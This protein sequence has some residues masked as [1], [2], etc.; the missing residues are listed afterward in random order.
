[1]VHL[2]CIL[3]FTDR[4]KTDSLPLWT[5]SSSF[6]DN[7]NLTRYRLWLE[8]QYGL[9]FEDYEALWRWST[10]QV[11]SFWKSIWDYFELSKNPWQGPVMSNDAMPDTQWF[12]GAQINYAEQIFRRYTNDHPAIL[13][14]SERHPLT[15]ISWSELRDKVGRLRSFL[16]NAGVHKGDRVAAFIPNIPEATYGFLA[17]SSIGAIWSSC[18]PDFGVSSV[19]DR[20]SQIEPKVLLVAD[21]YQ[22]NGKPYSK[23]DVINEI[24][25]ALPSVLRVILIPYLDPDLGKETVSKAVLWEEALCIGSEEL[26]FEQM[27]FNDPIWVLYSSGTTGA[28]KAITHSHGGV[29]LE[30]LKYLAFHNDVHPGERFFWFSTTGWMMWNYVQGALL[31]GAT[32]VLYDGSPGYPD[33]GILWKMAGDGKIE[34]FGTS[35]PYLVAC[36]K[37]SVEPAQE[38]D[39]SGLRSVSSTGAPLPPEAFDWIYAHVKQDLWLCSMSGGTDVCTAFVGGCPWKPVYS[40]EIQARGLGCSLFAL[41]ELG[42]PV[43][44]EVGEMVITKPMPSMPIYFWNDPGKKRY[45]ESYFEHYDKTWRHGDWVKITPTGGLMIYGRSDATLNRQG[46]RIGTA[47][48][49]RVLDQLPEIKDALIVNLELDSGQH[50]MPLFVIPQTGTE[51]HEQLRNKI[52]GLLRSACSPRHVPDEIYAVEEIPYTIS[53]KKMEAPVKKIL[54]GMSDAS[55]FNRDAMRNPKAMDYFFE[56]ADKLSKGD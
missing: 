7:A 49:Y 35:A 21:G 1:M 50:F 34:H 16:K 52:S 10:E 38:A 2:S 23:V 19:V 56:F 14:Q 24:V 5:P 8:Q 30:H 37:K 39:L 15:E 42:Q 22:Y 33:L 18:S 51:V 47:E 53:G 36:M 44:D 43:I 48:I 40:G 12:S 4:M 31:L 25:D 28:P 46:V 13:F 26:H 41:D 17:A 11:G 54:L 32:I 29:L 6:V 27:E 45:R 9:H 3:Y 55:S 20:F